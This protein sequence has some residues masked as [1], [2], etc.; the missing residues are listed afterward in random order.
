MNNQNSTP[1]VFFDRD[2]VIIPDEEFV[3]DPVNSIIYEDVPVSLNRLREAGFSLAIITNQTVV[4]RGL[5]SEEKMLELNEII[6]KDIMDKGGPSFDGFFYCPHH[7]ESTLLN[8]RVNCDCRKPKPGLIIKASQELNINLQKSFMIGDRISDIIAGFS[9][10]C[11]T[12]LLRTGKHKSPPI[13][14]DI[15]IDYSIKP[16][17]QCDHLIEAVDWI[18]EQT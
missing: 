1:G 2:G 17:F 12:I 14:S 18:L 10:G 8:Y 15:P 4:A 9:A 6:L 3:L 7:P 13:I 16:D 5:I 11:R